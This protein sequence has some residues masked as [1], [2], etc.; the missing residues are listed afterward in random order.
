M[1]AISAA[2]AVTLALLPLAPVSAAEGEGSPRLSAGVRA[3]AGDRVLGTV[4]VASSLGQLGPGALAV[5]AAV[6]ATAQGRP[7]ATGWLLAAIAVGGLFGSLWWTW[8]PAATERAARTVMFA[9]LGIGTPLALAAAATSSLPATAALFAVSGLFLGPFTGALFTV[10]EDRAPEAARAQVF[11]IS[12]GL[13][14]TAAAAGAALGGAIAGFAAPVQL[15]LVAGSPLLA[16][17]LGSLVLPRRFGA[18]STSR[19]M[20]S[21]LP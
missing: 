8:R 18:A 15:L 17:L 7:G 20:R 3:I 14:T 9:L 12:A 11:T 6:L 1:A 16:G 13:K 5:V 21:S 10:R 4:T 19:A 2:G